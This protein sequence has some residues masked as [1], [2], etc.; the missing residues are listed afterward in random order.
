MEDGGLAM[1][2][3]Q[4]FSRIWYYNS[5]K[6]GHEEILKP[7]FFDKRMH[8]LYP[9]NVLFVNDKDD[10]TFLRCVQIVTTEV[11]GKKQK[12]V[13]LQSVDIAGE[14]IAALGVKND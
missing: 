12:H 14:T 4:M 10:K 5:K 3:G 6:E 8:E 2:G 13:E 1:F 9:G 11:N 7:G